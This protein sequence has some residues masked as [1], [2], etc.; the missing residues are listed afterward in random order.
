MRVQM[1]QVILLEMKSICFAQKSEI[2][3]AGVIDFRIM[4]D[5]YDNVGVK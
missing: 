4:V 5:S 2:P 1:C 3:Q